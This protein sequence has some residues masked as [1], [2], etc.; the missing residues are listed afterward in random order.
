MK[1]SIV[2]PT[3]NHC[4]DLLKPCIES[5]FKYTDMTDV[6]LIVSANG[7]TDNTKWY[8]DSLKYQFDSLGFGNHFKIVWD[9]KPLG[10]AKACNAGIR[11]CSTEKVILFSNDCILLHQEKNTWLHLFEKPFIENDKCGVTC[12]VKAHSSEANR[13]F[14]IFFCVMIDG[15]VF[16]AIG[17][18]PEDYGAGGCEDVDFCIQAEDAGFEVIECL[19]K[20]LVNEELFSGNFPIYH[21]GEGTVHDESLVPNWGDTFWKNKL[22]IARKYNPEWPPLKELEND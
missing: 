3:Y 8:L 22:K 2:I 5:I 19:E 6:E 15:K 11:A 14:A 10:Y 7:C 4:D 9:D 21:M 17:L 1:Y 20:Y 18:V 16:D 13:D 12:V